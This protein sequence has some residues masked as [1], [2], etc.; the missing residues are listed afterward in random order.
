MSVRVFKSNDD[1]IDGD[2]AAVYSQTVREQAFPRAELPTWEF[3]TFK[4]REVSFVSAV[5][6]EFE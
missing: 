5:S 6:Q 1:I 2:G 4:E 3:K